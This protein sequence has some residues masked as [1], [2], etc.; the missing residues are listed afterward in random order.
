MSALN[1]H[2]LAYVEVE[3]KALDT[4]LEVK[5]DAEGGGGLCNIAGTLTVIGNK[6]NAIFNKL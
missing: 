4:R 3:M 5:M 2:T 1:S 6:V